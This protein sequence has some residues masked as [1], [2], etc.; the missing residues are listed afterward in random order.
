MGDYICQASH[1]TCHASPIS[2][3][4]DQIAIESPDSMMRNVY[5]TN[6]STM[7]DTCVYTIKIL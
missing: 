2:V 7:I 4:D 3:I 1:A 6:A 5:P